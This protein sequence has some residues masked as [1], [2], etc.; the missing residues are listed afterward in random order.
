MVNKVKVAQLCSTLCNPM[1]YT[2]HR[3]FQARIVE[4]VAIPF[5][6]GS[7]QPRDQTQVSHMTGRFFTS[8]QGSPR[9]LEW[10]AYS[11]SSGSSQPRNW[12]GVSCIAGRFFTNWAEGSPSDLGSGALRQYQSFIPFHLVFYL[13]FSHSVT[14]E[15]LHH[16]ELQHARLPC[17]SPTPGVHPNPC[18]LSQWCHPTISS[19]VISFYLSQHQ[20]LFKWVSSS[21]QVAKVLVFQLQHQSFQWIFRTDFL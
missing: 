15:S 8:H 17:P 9:I 2:V 14:S 3:I 5:S 11:F 12:T 4:W 10:V 19:S 7:S 13:L 20:G 16:Y 1:E 18:P 6:R 21:H